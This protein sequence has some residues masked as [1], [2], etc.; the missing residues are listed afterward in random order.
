MSELTVTQVAK[1]FNGAAAL[2]PLDLSVADGTFC[3]MLGSSG[4][5]KSTL[6]RIIAGLEEPDTGSI[7][8]GARDVSKLPVEKRNIGFVFQNYALFPHLSVLSNV[9]YGLRARRAPRAGAK[10]KAEEMLGLV[11]LAGFETRSPAQLSG[12]Q[13]QRVALARALVTSPELLLLDEPLSALDRKIRGEMQ[14]ELKRIHR[15]TGLTTVMVTHDQEEAM[16]LGDQVMMLDRGAVQQ[17]D[18][19]EAMYREPGNRFVA[20]FLGG[21][22]LGR[23]V[24]RAS[25]GAPRVEVGSLSVRAAQDDLADGAAVDVLVMA[26]SVRIVGD[27][28]ADAFPGTLASLSFFGPFARAEITAGELTVPVTMLSQE[29]EALR[30]GDG[31]RFT[32]APEGLH[33]FASDLERIE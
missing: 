3:I 5:G 23:G 18:S 7:R 11:G 29:A 6:L 13:Q 21:Q 16:D 25:G 10:R 12:G 32:I 2:L 22:L 27:G 14:R 19:P 24:V 15:E 33:A 28:S 1:T 4:S 9:M 8:I 31:V 26:E 20:Q 30:V 17:D